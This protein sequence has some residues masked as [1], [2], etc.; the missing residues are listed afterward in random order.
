MS[1]PWCKFTALLHEA[2]NSEPQRVQKSKLILQH[3]RVGVARVR[4]GPLVGAES[5]DNE[6]EE[7]DAQKSGR[8]VYPDFQRQRRKERE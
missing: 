2:T 8:H 5:G 7:A 4:I 3:I 6:Q 1:L